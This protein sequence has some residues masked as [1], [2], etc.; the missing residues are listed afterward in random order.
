[1]CSVSRVGLRWNPL[2]TLK[3]PVWGVIVN[4]STPHVTGATPGYLLC[5]CTWWCFLLKTVFCAVWETS[6]IPSVPWQ[7]PRLR[8]WRAQPR[9]LFWNRLEHQETPLQ[10]KQQA[11]RKN[12]IRKHNSPMMP[13][14]CKSARCKLVQG[15]HR[16]PLYYSC[17]Q[18]G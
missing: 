18:N 11:P 3:R 7:K 14:S 13:F 16:W 2:V 1:M 9:T 6:F 15:K 17:N 12:R 5:Y 4:I 10:D 8:M